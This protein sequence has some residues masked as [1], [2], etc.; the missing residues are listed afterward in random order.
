MSRGKL[1]SSERIGTQLMFIKAT[2]AADSE[3]GK[4][5]STNPMAGAAMSGMFRMT[6]SSTGSSDALGGGITFGHW[7]W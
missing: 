2:N 7:G 3:S 1:E 6:A 4:K 5:Q